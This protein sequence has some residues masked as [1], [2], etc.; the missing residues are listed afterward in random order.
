MVDVYA[1]FNNTYYCRQD[2]EVISRLQHVAETPFKRVS[3]TE[4]IDI[5]KQAI[6]DGKKFEE[7]NIEWG[8]DLGSEH[9]RCAHS[10]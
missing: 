8:M 2:P 9:E 6:A 1:Q 7:T 10:L 4:V 5:L 3:Y